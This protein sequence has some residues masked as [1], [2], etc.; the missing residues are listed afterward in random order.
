MCISQENTQIKIPWMK[1]KEDRTGW[2]CNATISAGNC[3]L[4]PNARPLWPTPPPP[5]IPQSTKKSY[6]ISNMQSATV[7]RQRGFGGFGELCMNIPR[8][9]IFMKYFMLHACVSGR[10]ILFSPMNERGEDI[11]R[12]SMIYRKGEI[13]R[14]QR[15]QI[16]LGNPS[17][18]SAAGKP[19]VYIEI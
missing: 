17:F 9:Q 10:P 16:A 11:Y 5:T 2:T 4:S 18:F 12:G 6:F 8:H 13:A 1:K 14:R 19:C 3:L 15:N 7:C